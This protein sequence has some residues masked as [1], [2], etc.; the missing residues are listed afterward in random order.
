[1]LSN[2]QGRGK[3]GRFSVCRYVVVAVLFFKKSTVRHQGRTKKGAHIYKGT[4]LSRTTPKAPSNSVKDGYHWL[5]GEDAPP[6][7]QE[8]HDKAAQKRREAEAKRRTE[9]FEWFFG[10]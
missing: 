9:G 8:A 3:R 1:V 2:G 4:K 7:A 10:R 6:D 5:F